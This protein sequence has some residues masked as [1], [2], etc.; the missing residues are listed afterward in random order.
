[1]KMRFVWG[2]FVAMA[3]GGCAASPGLIKASNI[4]TRND[5]FQEVANGGTVPRGYADLR[6]VSSLKTHRPGRYPFERKSHGTT[7]YTLLVNIDGQ[8][9]RLMGNITEEESEPRALRDPEAGEGIRYL[10]EKTLRLRAGTHRIVV[11]IPEDGVVA[12]RE[13]VLTAGSRHSLVLEPA[14]GATAG[15]QRPGF[16]GVTSFY[17]G[18]SGLRLQ[19]D[20]KP[21]L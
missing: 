20:G 11:A 17:E 18:I 7:D 10:F 13:I 19:L 9:V 2:L 12:E 8:A 1:M 14:Y 16:Y 5:V 6:I 15:K 3:L 4:S 21:L